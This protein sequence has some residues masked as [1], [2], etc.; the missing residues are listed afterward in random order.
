[1][2]EERIADVARDEILGIIFTPAEHQKLDDKSNFKR[3]A[4]V[5]MEDFDQVATNAIGL[6][7]YFFEILS[8]AEGKYEGFLYIGRALIRNVFS[9]LVEVENFIYNHF[10]TIE[11]VQT[12][13]K[14]SRD[15]K[16]I[17]GLIFEP[18]SERAE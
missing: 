16:K 4:G 11:I 6:F 15:D 17:I 1:M 9:H 8:E 12:W 10:G 13:E 18:A 2:R 14:C 5:T 7:D 3:G